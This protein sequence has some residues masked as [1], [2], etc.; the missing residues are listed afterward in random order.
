VPIALVAIASVSLVIWLYLTFAR[1]T[2]WRVRNF[3]DDIAKHE[4]PTTWPSVVAV[5][6]ARNEAAT[7]RQAVT[8]LLQQ[9]YP[10]EFSVIVVD[11]HSKDA[12]AQL[13]QQ[14]ARDLT[15]ESQIEI[16]NAPPLPQGWT[17]KLWALNSA[18]GTPARAPTTSIP[19]RSTAT[20][21]TAS[22]NP[23]TPASVP[24][25]YWFTDA[26]IL[27]GPDTLHRLVARA[28]SNHL[29]LTS[30]MVLLQAKTLPERALIPAFLFFFLKLYPPSWIANPKAKTAGAAGGCILLRIEALHRIGGLAAIRTQ[31]IDDCALAQAVKVAHPPLAPVAQALL[32]VLRR[33]L[34]RNMQPSLADQEFSGRIWMGL[35]R[36]SI[37]LRAYNT[38]AEIRDMIARTAFTQLQYNPLLLLGTI[39]GMFL[40]Y[41]APIAMLFAHNPTTRILAAS[42]WALMSLL[43]LPT[44]RFYSLSP[45]WAPLLPAV[46]AFYSYATVLSAA[47]YYLGR[48]AQWKGRSQAHS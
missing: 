35:T 6:P 36:R 27:H 5:V 24:T 34:S 7:I 1:G 45:L 37:S 48:G 2:F 10:G 42:T 43:Y 20:S 17:G 4:A 8:S 32:P 13:A 47:R 23:S 26:D 40:T 12:T 38:F 31:V 25:Y 21:R 33:P 46:S 19:P 18:T 14:A 29:D 15:A 39:A 9:N 28:E 11:D 30:L 41:L 22:S 16:R 44:L 3:D